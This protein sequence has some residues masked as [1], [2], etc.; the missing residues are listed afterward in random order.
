MSRE[1]LD[2]TIDLPAGWNDLTEEYLEALPTSV[3]SG[4][5]SMGDLDSDGPYVTMSMNALDPES[6]LSTLDDSAMDSWKDT[7]GDPELGDTGYSETADGGVI[8][9]A[10][11]TGDLGGERRTE[12][13]AHILY[14]PYYMYVEIDTPEG[15]EAN[16]HAM[17]DA[18]STV[19]MSGPLEVG[20]RAG[21][22][23]TEAGRWSSYCNTITAAAQDGWQYQFAYNYDATM[24][25][26]PEPTD[27]LGQWGVTTDDGEFVVIVDRL[28]E[29][30][31]SEAL[32]HRSVPADVGETATTKNGFTIEL[33]A[34]EIFAAPNGTV[35]LRVDVSST[36]PGGTAA[37]NMRTYFFEDDGGGVTE[38][39]VYENE[40]NVVPQTD[41]LEPF[42]ATLQT[43]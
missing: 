18:L 42:I 31:M 27:Y 22:P 19:T 20:D 17:L 5:W 11:V 38:V 3:L 26:C 24:W 32:E 34:E 30:S 8:T 4:Y 41:W 2:Y 33:V 12:H 25:K 21:A 7:L 13:F 39:Y 6:D 36:A 40:S 23:V 43:P 14:G 37:A 1:Y 10:S 35:G 29:T 15:D 28:A 16:A 9:W